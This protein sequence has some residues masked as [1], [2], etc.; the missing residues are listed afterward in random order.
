MIKSNDKK[1]LLPSEFK[2]K[3]NLNLKTIQTEIIDDP[4]KNTFKSSNKANY[5]SKNNNCLVIS[6]DYKSKN[7]IIETIN[8][9]TINVLKTEVESESDTISI[10]QNNYIVMKNVNNWFYFK[11]GS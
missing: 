3:Y 5:N 2:L 6:N 8:I 4:Y 9:N 11:I 10:C 1:F 7:R